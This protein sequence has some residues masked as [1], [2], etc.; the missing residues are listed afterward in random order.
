MPQVYTSFSSRALA[1]IAQ[2]AESIEANQRI[3]DKR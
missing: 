1:A 3:P 2:S